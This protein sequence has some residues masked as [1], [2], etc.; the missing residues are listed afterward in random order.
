MLR[1]VTCKFLMTCSTK[2]PQFSGVKYWSYVCEKASFVATRGSCAQGSST[3]NFQQFTQVFELP[4]MQWPTY[5]VPAS[6]VV[7]VGQMKI[8][9]IALMAR[10][11]CKTPQETLPSA[12]P[13]CQAS[14]SRQSFDVNYFVP[15]ESQP[16]LPVTGAVDSVYEVVSVTYRTGR[17]AYEDHS[18]NG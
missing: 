15:S 13:V 8:P 10:S 12:Q 3:K 17:S 2:E 5:H 4:V 16:A 9:F 7:N 11:A 6:I 14:V 1:I 18:G